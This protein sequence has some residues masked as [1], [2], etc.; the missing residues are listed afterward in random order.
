[1][2]LGL[3]VVICTWNRCE[4][5]RQT[6]ERMT[7]LSLPSGLEWELVVVN[8]RS[9]DATDEVLGSFRDRLPLRRVFEERPGQSNARN[10]A[11]R[12]ARGEYIVWTDD[13]VMVDP[14]WLIAYAAAFARWPRA[15]FFG[16]P[17]EPWFEGEPPAW[18]RA[19]IQ[20]VE[21]AYA[22]LDLGTDPVPLSASTFPYGA[23]MAV[24]RQV[25]DKVRYDPGLGLRPGSAMRSEEMALVRHLA[26]A[27]EEGWWVPAARVTH[28]IPKARQTIAYLREYYFG[29]GEYLGRASAPVRPSLLGRPLWL[30]REMVVSEV[31]YQLWRA[32][33][34]SERWLEELKAA[35]VAR[36]R[37][38]WYGAGFPQ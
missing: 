6:L 28:F 31:R 15:T 33:R 17:I 2:P 5:L 3:T 35:S 13:D 25:Y 32:A 16:G 12:E 4:L 22:V 24:R 20:R 7:R 36:G 1:M 9:T 19:G 11:I 18:L 10:T 21:A 37:F 38:R 30:W 23:N 14:G 27:G 29:W 8:N 26:D 34:T